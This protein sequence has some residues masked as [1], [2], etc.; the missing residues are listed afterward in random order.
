MWPTEA[1][2]DTWVAWVATC[3][4][5]AARQFELMERMAD[6]VAERIGLGPAGSA[7]RTGIVDLGTV[8]S[9]RQV[10]ESCERVVHGVREINDAAMRCYFDWADHAANRVAEHMFFGFRAARPGRDAPASDKSH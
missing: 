8:R 7:A 4:D 6:Q 3:Q 5:I 10:R 2:A 1:A 9:V